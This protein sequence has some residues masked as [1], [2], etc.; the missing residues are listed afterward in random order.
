MAR[1]KKRVFKVL[2]NP[3]VN[4]VLNLLKIGTVLTAVFLFPK[5]VKGISDL[6]LNNKEN[7]TWGKYDQYRL[8]QIVKRLVKRKLLS[9]EEKNGIQTV[10]LTENG[11]KQILKYN[12]EKIT[13]EKPEKWDG[14]WHVVIFDIDE[15]K[16][17][18]RDVLRE[19]IKNL[20]FFKLQESVFIHPYPC[21]KEI[22]FLR[23]VYHIGNEVSV[24]TAINLEE[25]NYLRNYF[26]L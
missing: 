19:K 8:R 22:A 5:S 4:T 16:S 23:Q 12:L 24:F 26:N 2:E 20:G 11:R 14:R 15:K 6:F 17:H 10:I 25:E 21:E 9:I 3:K 18:L 13:I 1:K 7:E